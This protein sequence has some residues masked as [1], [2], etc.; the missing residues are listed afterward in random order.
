[1]QLSNKGAML[2]G[3]VALCFFVELIG[4]W[5]VS[6]SALEWYSHLKKPSWTPPNFLFGPVWTIL[7]ILMAISVWFVW[8]TPVIN[9]SKAPAYIFFALQLIFNVFWSI[10]FFGEKSIFFALLNLIF[11]EVLVVGMIWYFYKI[12]KIAALLLI[13]Y[14]LWLGYALIINISVWY[15]NL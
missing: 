9:Q 15:L 5:W 4:G 13:P 7:Y 1:M 8:K 3:F 12:S 6:G 14:F 2:L 11:I 10:L